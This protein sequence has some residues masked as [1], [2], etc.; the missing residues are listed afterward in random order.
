MGRSRKRYWQGFFTGLTVGSGASVASWLIA[1]AVRGR[2]HEKI[3][4]L[5][6]SIQIGRPVQ[7]VFRAWANFEQLPSL[8]RMIEDVQVRGNRSHWVGRIDGRRIE[9]DAELTQRVENRAL[10]WKSV[11]GPKHTGRIDFSSIGNDTLVHV[12]M[13]YAPPMGSIGSSLAERS[14]VSDIVEA[15]IEQALRDFKAAL[16]GKGQEGA[17]EERGMQRRM[18]TEVNQQSRATGTY[19]IAELSGHTQTSRFGGPPNPV[20]THP[21]EPKT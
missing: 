3:V 2:Q 4:R 14:G 7:E 11:S 1:R 10:A 9:W 12:V 15:Q 5:E 19:G 13:N 20:D 8:L 17:E 21:A 18:S 16:E 6:K